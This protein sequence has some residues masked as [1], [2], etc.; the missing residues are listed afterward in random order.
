M[1]PEA[2]AALKN[3]A[4]HKNYQIKYFHR[5]TENRQELVILLGE[6]HD[7]EDL[8]EILLGQEVVKH[9]SVIGVENGAHFY[10]SRYFPDFVAWLYWNVVA[11]CAHKQGRGS[12]GAIPAR[13][14]STPALDGKN[15]KRIDLEMGC[16]ASAKDNF[17]GAL[18]LIWNIAEF[19]ALPA[20]WASCYFG[21]PLVG[22]CGGT[23]LACIAY[24]LG[25]EALILRGYLPRNFHRIYYVVGVDTRDSGIAHNINEF[26]AQNQDQ[27]IL[28]LPAVVGST[29]LPGIEYHL[30]TT[31]GFSKL[32]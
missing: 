22:V 13:G 25:S 28:V 30:V 6:V 26:F 29:H 15:I 23:G 2:I 32:K 12:T 27:D 3:A 31:Y 24:D 19:A 20:T 5:Q 7:K 8:N 1:E 14:F 17:M 18:N 16:K 9:F 10:H 11:P 4:A 21:W